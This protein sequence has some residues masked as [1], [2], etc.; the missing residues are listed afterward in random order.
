MM[1][2]VKLADGR[3]TFRFWSRGQFIATL[4]TKV[5]GLDEARYISAFA[6][7]QKDDTTWEPVKL[8]HVR[9]NS[10]SFVRLVE[11]A[12]REEFEEEYGSTT[13]RLSTTQLVAVLKNDTDTYPEAGTV[14]VP[15]ALE[16]LRRRANRGDVDALDAMREIGQ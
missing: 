10:V 7:W 4:K 1:I 8:F 12:E 6:R 9:P 16:Q 13:F 3:T 15:A 14:D 5:E 2:D 11:R